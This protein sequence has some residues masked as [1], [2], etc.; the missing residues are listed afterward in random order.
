MSCCNCEF[1][2]AFLGYS[3]WS[4]IDAYVTNQ[5]VSMPGGAIYLLSIDTGTGS[6]TSAVPPGPG[7]PN[8]S[9]PFKV[10]N[11]NRKLNNEKVNK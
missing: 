11:L 1:L 4:P 6:Y 5:G 8:W 10:E 7:N 3:A 2:L 9:G